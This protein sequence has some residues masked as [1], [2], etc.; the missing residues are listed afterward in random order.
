MSDS[1]KTVLEKV[2]KNKSRVQLKK[3]KTTEKKTP[4]KRYGSGGSKSE[5]GSQDTTV[6]TKKKRTGK[7]SGIFSKKQ[8]TSGYPEETSPLLYKSV[9]EESD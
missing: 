9:N 4:Q 6:K 5:D 1:A 2:R 7:I 8:K 3:S